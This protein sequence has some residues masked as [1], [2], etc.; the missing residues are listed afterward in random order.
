MPKGAI[1]IV[2]RAIIIAIERSLFARQCQISPCWP[3]RP[4][5][6]R[7]S[8]QKH[9]LMPGDGR[10]GSLR[11]KLATPGH[12]VEPTPSQVAGAKITAA[13]DTGDFA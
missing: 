7:R 8:R 9:N 6:T 3:N 2:K 10:S 4:H 12:V 5:M 13:A 1:T 11:G